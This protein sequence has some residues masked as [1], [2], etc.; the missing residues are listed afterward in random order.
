MRKTY[1]IYPGRINASALLGLKL[2]SAK[3]VKIHQF[4]LQS[5]SDNQ[6]V[7]FYEEGTGKQLSQKWVFNARE[8]VISPFSIPPLIVPERVGRDI[9]LNLANATFVNFVVQYTNEDEDI[10]RE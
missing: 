1:L 9:G 3:A 4:S 2:S 5:E 7:Y 6:T 10:Y 8:G